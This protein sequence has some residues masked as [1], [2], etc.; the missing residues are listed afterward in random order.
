[1]AENKLFRVNCYIRIFE[2]PDNG[3]Y[4]YYIDYYIE[5]SGSTWKKSNRKISKLRRRAEWET[6]KRKKYKANWKCNKK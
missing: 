5:R 6:R 2:A 1:M 3:I 4:Y